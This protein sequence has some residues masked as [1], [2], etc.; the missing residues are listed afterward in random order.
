[1]KGKITREDEMVPCARERLKGNTQ[2]R[3]HTTKKRMVIQ[4]VIARGVPCAATR[5][6]LGCAQASLS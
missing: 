4:A 6:L 3:T 1:V 5:Q 2:N